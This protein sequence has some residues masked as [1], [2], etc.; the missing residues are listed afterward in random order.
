MNRRWF[1]AAAACAV[2]LGASTASAAIF[3]TNAS[4]IIA[5]GAGPPA[6][7]AGAT[8]GASS[9]GVGS[10]ATLPAGLFSGTVQTAI[11]PPL[12]G[13]LD[14]IGV[15]AAGGWPGGAAVNNAFSFNGIT[16]TMSLS[17]S[18][19]LLVGATSV[20]EIP[21]GVVGVGGTQ[22]FHV[23]T[24]TTGV[25]HANP[26][27]LGMVTLMGALNGTPHTLMGTGVDL[28]RAGGPGTL[29][30][31]SP[32]HVSLGT[33]GTLAGLATL[34][35]SYVP[36]PGSVVLLGMGVGGLLAVGRKARRRSRALRPAQDV[37]MR[38]TSPGR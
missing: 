13:I 8:S 33:F 3:H 28:R 35:I 37:G 1:D 24:L 27:Q 10:A 32:T 4:L 14:R 7:F 34:T 5:F 36:E 31:V 38:P 2:V 9:E 30:L 20:A 12:F 17:A 22:M 15:G 16:G 18:A 26:Y 11:D 23:L 6:G 29:V 21:L 25:I 19:Y